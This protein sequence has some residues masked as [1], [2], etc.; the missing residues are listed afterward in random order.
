[1]YVPYHPIFGI[2]CIAFGALLLIATLG[3]LL[4]RIII[5]IFALG[6][7][8]YG[9]SLMNIPTMTVIRKTWFFRR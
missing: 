5:G 2:V 4:F 6:I 3:D 7:I 9:F 8:N 1:M